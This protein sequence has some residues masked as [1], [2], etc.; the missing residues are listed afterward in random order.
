MRF[1]LGVLVLFAASAVRADHLASSPK[2]VRYLSLDVGPGEVRVRSTVLVGGQAAL[3]LRQRADAN[4]DGRLDLDERRRL[5]DGLAEDLNRSLVLR[6]DGGVRPPRWDTPSLSLSD[7]TVGA[8]RFTLDQS[9]SIAV[10]PDGRHTLA[11]EDRAALES[12]AETQ[13]RVDAQSGFVEAKSDGQPDP[14]GRLFRWLGA[15]PVG[16]TRTLTIAFDAAVSSPKRGL[17]WRL[18]LGTVLI[19]TGAMLGLRQRRA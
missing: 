16:E 2:V 18:I 17:P 7:D 4:G 9:G 5:R 19:V 13:I 1:G 15:R 10:P 12:L 11:L 14:A 3:P 8:A 6:L